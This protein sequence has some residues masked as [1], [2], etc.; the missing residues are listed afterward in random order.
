MLDLTKLWLTFNHRNVQNHFQ[1]DPDGYIDVDDETMLVTKY[2]G[3]NFKMLVT[4]GANI[5]SPTSLTP[6]QIVLIKN[7]V[8]D[9]S[10][11]NGQASQGVADFQLHPN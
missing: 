11:V 9:G 7:Q 1:V 2:V 3:D 8:A 10:P 6:T 5:K 4:V